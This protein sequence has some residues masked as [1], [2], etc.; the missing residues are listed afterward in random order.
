MTAQSVPSRYARL[1][2]LMHW[3]MLALFVGVYACIEL[4]GLM[5]KGS[6]ARGLFLG[7]HSLF[8]I[9]IFALVWI[10][11]VARLQPRPPILPAPSAWQT[12]LSHLMHLVLY[13]LMIATPLLAWLMLSA[14]GK[15]V[16]YFEFFLP[17]APVTV[18]PDQA[19]FFKHWHEQLGSA[20]YWLIG[21]HALAGLFH[22]YWVGDNTLKRMLPGARR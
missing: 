3:L 20:G 11:L 17:A 7:L 19:R 22:H 16:P 12:G 2:I 5:P 4:K 13:A 9:S 6:T 8:G 18:D 1:S 14:A 15:P 21:L 10:R